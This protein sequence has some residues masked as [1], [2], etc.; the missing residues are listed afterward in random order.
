RRFLEE[1]LREKGFV[2]FSSKTNFIL[3][4][5]QEPLYERLLE[6]EILIRDCSNFRGLRQGFYRI[7]VRSRE[8]N[9]ILLRAIGID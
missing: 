1:G 3:F 9:E 6:K 2:V 8:E 7:A 4:Y 5:S